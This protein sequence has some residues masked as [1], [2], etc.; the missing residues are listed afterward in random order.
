[1]KALMTAFAL[2]SFVAATTLPVVGH[3]ATTAEHAMHK[4]KKRG[5]KRVAHHRKTSSKMR[6]PH[7]A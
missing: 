2:L 4:K 3:A 5:A 1:M 6:K 7:P